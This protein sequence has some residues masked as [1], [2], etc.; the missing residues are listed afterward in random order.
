MTKYRVGIF[1]EQGGYIIVDAKNENEARELANTFV[2][3][4][5]ISSDEVDITH[6]DTYIVDEPEVYHD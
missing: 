5:G 3:E 4:F 2:E 6:R 1:E